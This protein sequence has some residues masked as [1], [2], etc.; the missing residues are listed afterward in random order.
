V[1]G[2]AQY[3]AL[4]T[5]ENG[6]VVSGAAITWTTDNLVVASVDENGIVTGFAGGSATVTASAA[7]V[8]GTA[9]F[10]VVPVIIFCKPDGN[11]T[12]GAG[13]RR[14][15]QPGSPIS[16]RQPRRLCRPSAPGN[17]A[18]VLLDLTTGDTTTLTPDNTDNGIPTIDGDRVIYVRLPPTGDWQLLTYDLNAGQETQFAAKT[19][20]TAS[21][22]WP[23]QAIE[24]RGT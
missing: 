5:D 15:E 22:G 20:T 12:H 21:A 4:L 11:S 1:G 7:G 10:H 8:T 18:I 19:A 14:P 23:D 17:Q 2:R 6:A 3:T 9:S 24:P 16:H 13:D